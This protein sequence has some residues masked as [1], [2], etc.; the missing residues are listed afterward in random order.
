MSLSLADYSA[1]IRDS[2][3]DAKDAVLRIPPSLSETSLTTVMGSCQD[4]GK[5]DRAARIRAL[6]SS[7]TLE[8]LFLS[9]QDDDARKEAY[10]LLAVH[11]KE[12]VDARLLAVKEKAIVELV[13]LCEVPIDTAQLCATQIDSIF[14]DIKQLVLASIKQDDAMTP[15]RRQAIDDFNASVKVVKLTIISITK[16]EKNISDVQQKLN[17]RFDS[18]D[19]VGTASDTTRSELSN[20]RKELEGQRSYQER[21]LLEH[22]NET[23]RTRTSDARITS[24]ELIIPDSLVSKGRGLELIDNS[25]AH[26]CS[27]IPQF[28]TISAYHKRIGEDYNASTGCFWQPPSKANNFSDVPVEFREAF[29]TQNKAYALYLLQRVT[30]E[31][32]AAVLSIYQYGIHKQFDSKADEDD[33]LA[34][35][36]GLVSISR[37]SAAAYRE[38]IDNQLNAAADLFR[39]GNPTSKIKLLRPFLTEALRLK[40]RIKWTIGKKI[41]TTLALRHSTFAVDLAYLKETAP[42]TEDSAGH[43][44]RLFAQITKSCSDI[45]S[46]QGDRWQDVQ[47]HYGNGQSNN[48]SW[49]PGTAR[50]ECRFGDKCTRADCRYTHKNGKG[51]S[52]SNRNTGKGGNSSDK[53]QAKSCN[54]RTAGKGKRYCNTCFKNG[55]QKGKIEDKSGD[56]RSFKRA[57]AARSKVENKS[58]AKKQKD[59]FSPQQLQVLQQLHGE[60]VTKRS[61]F[62]A[63]ADLPA[64]PVSFKRAAVADRLGVR[65]DD[66]VSNALQAITLGQQ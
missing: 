56:S 50:G 46:I 15:Q 25:S 23:A 63:T 29:I 14:V 10:S 28:Y 31:A 44:D 47:A 52:G 36:F 24:V 59:V 64:G 62:D 27:H 32:A 55:L 8:P 2:L 49:S 4:S 6:K 48:N 7:S 53:C 61:L 19:I 1:R 21:Q 22:F 41:I 66:Q 20:L 38:E 42:N 17:D 26:M 13:E 3:V 45:E 58:N 30:P 5:E 65:S 18:S 60:S 37:P 51:K 54:Q 35:Y 43:I 57:A 16:I 34:I 11:I 33:G 40:M 39:R 12:R 9:L